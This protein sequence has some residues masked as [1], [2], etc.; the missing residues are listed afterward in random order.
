M[1]G[2]TLSDEQ[3]RAVAAYVYSLT[4]PDVPQPS[5]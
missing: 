4:H 1:G 3:L 5:S 2:A